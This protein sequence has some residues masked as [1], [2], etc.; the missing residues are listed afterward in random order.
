MI[1]ALLIAAFA[2]AGN[3]SGPGIVDSGAS[4]GVTTVPVLELGSVVCEA[5]S[6][7]LASPTL[8][9]PQVVTATAVSLARGRA[10]TTMAFRT[11]AVSVVATVA[12]S[13]AGIGR[14]PWPLHLFHLGGVT[15]RT[16]T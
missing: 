9:Q 5:P 1:G 3:Y 11:A 14:R 12:A 2:L 4:C 13:A 10:R 16:C 8:Y 7:I 6:Q 15:T